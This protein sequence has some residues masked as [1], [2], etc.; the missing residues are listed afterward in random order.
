MS[1]AK[2]WMNKSYFLLNC[3]FFF[4]IS[5]FLLLF[6]EGFYFNLFLLNNLKAHQNE[7]FCYTC[8]KRSVSLSRIITCVSTNHPAFVFVHR[9]NITLLQV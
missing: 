6:F 9:D 8:I 5:A 3:I 1:L 2:G 4:M 7:M